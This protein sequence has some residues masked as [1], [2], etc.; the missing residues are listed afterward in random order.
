MQNLGTIYTYRERMALLPMKQNNY[1]HRVLPHLFF[2][3]FWYF[4][5]DK[6]TMRFF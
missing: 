1:K 4:F 3:F 5:C 6:L 2:F